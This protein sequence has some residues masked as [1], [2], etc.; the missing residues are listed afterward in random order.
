[1]PCCQKYTP[2][3]YFF[4]YLGSDH[5]FYNDK[6][7]F[8]DEAE[9]ENNGRENSHRDGEW[10]E[11]GGD[12]H[13]SFE[14]GENRDFDG[15]NGEEHR[16]FQGQREGEHPEG[17]EFHH[18]RDGGDMEDNDRPPESYMG[19]RR[20]L[21]A[22]TANSTSK[23]TNSAAPALPHYDIYAALKKQELGKT[24]S[25]F[26][27]QAGARTMYES[28][29]KEIGKEESTK[30]AVPPLPENSQN[31][32]VYDQLKTQLKDESKMSVQ[33]PMALKESKSTTQ[34]ETSEPSASASADAKL[35]GNDDILQTPENAKQVDSKLLKDFRQRFTE[36]NGFKSVQSA[37]EML[38]ELE[39]LALT[40]QKQIDAHQM[41]G[42]FYKSALLSGKRQELPIASGS[43][44]QYIAQ[45]TQ[46]IHHST[47]ILY[48]SSNSALQYSKK[49]RPKHNIKKNT[50]FPNVNNKLVMRH[51]RKSKTR[52]HKL[53]TLIISDGDRKK[54]VRYYTAPT[55][56]NTTV[57]L[58]QP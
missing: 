13:K 48:R 8:N 41:N 43:K 47:D 32:N 45:K 44:R 17:A 25:V 24:L 1:V 55:V 38:N 7:N 3:D 22:A 51:T 31:T 54:M 18:D 11:R 19:D 29:K 53:K 46:P 14:D 30:P 50:A 57:K 39:E 16:Y 4:P 34:L 40:N 20:G 15:P 23:G 2:T 33:Q 12:E 42:D 9:H 6:P 27:Q 5:D 37:D 36:E 49:R 56:K 10:H 35:D 21:A 58:R 52:K 26:Q 28:L